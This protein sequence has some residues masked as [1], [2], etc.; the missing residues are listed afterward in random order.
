ML[1]VQ[2]KHQ[3]QQEQELDGKNFRECGELLN[4]KMLLLKM[5]RKIY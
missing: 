5:K 4:G 2:V 1:M 3:G